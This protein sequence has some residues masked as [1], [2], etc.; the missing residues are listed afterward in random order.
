MG[1]ISSKPDLLCFSCEEKLNLFQRGKHCKQCERTFCT[2]CSNRERLGGVR[3]R[4]CHVCSINLEKRHSVGLPS[5]Y[6]D[7]HISMPLDFE[8]KISVKHNRDKD[9]FEGIP[10]LWAELLSMPPN[11]VRK[12][13][14]TGHLSS[15]LAPALPNRRILLKIE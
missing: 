10:A 15:N 12:Q 4:V 13:T 2:N 7:M 6:D 8:H 3:Q 11:K 5:T 1:K 9:F 14:E